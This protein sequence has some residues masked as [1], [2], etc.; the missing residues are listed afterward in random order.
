M[1]VKCLTNSKLEDE[2]CLF[3]CVKFRHTLSPANLYFKCEHFAGE[4]F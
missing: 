3:L 4:T 2:V 1:Y